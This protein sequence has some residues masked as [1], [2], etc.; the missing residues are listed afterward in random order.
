MLISEILNKKKLSSTTKKSIIYN[1][2]IEIFKE[3]KKIDIKDYIIS[4]Q[5]LENIFLVKT[6]KPIINTELY[7]LNEKIKKQSL[8]KL[9][10]I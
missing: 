8:E 10:K 6:K 9:N 4:V 2:I 1:T 3:E 7:L 5:E